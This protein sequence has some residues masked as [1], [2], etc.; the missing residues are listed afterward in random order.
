MSNLPEKIMV[1][2]LYNWL[3]HYNPYRQEWNAFQREEASQ[4]FNGTAKNV[5]SDQ[6]HTAC[7]RKAF[8][9]QLKLDKDV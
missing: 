5:V 6:S 1:Q 9:L 3:F 8:T 2:Q 7:V 4:Y